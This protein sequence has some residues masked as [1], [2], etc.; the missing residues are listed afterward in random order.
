M[1]KKVYEPPFPLLD[2]RSWPVSEEF[3]RK[4]FKVICVA[5]TPAI[6]LL[7][8]FRE[9]ECYWAFPLGRRKGSLIWPEPTTNTLCTAAEFIRFFRKVDS[10]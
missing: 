5:E 8:G 2:E 10:S 4:G 3:D 6:G 1:R 7:K 9:G